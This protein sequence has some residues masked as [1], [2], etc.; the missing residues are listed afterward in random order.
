MTDFK[1]ALTHW[2]TWLWGAAVTLLGVVELLPDWLNQLLALT[3]G[4]LPFFSADTVRQVSLA[5]G[6]AGL[7]AKG[8]RQAWVKEKIKSLWAW[9]LYLVAEKGG[10]AAKKFGLAACVLALGAG[11]VAFLIK[12]EDIRLKAYLDVANI[13]TICVGHTGRVVID[14]KDYGPVKLGMVLT[15]VQCEVLLK[16][17]TDGVTSALNKCVKRP[18]N[19]N[20]SDALTSLAFNIGNSGACSSQVVARINAGDMAGAAASFKNWSYATIGGVKKPVLRKRRDAEA[21]LFLTPVNDNPE[22]QTS[23]QRL[24]ALVKAGAQ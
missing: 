19:Q 6:A 7:I 24:Q 14:G 21:A 8:I 22:G 16:Q 4:E 17:D 12:A 5:L 10:A 3:G 23:E 11:G 1:T 20:Q 2:S 9:F 13:P 18:L 15:R